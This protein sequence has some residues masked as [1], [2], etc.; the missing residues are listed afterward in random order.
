MTS[1]AAERV[2]GW[3]LLGV[4]TFQAALALGAPWGEAAY[5]GANTGVLPVEQRLSSAVAAPVYLALAGVAFGTVGTPTV[6]RRVLRTASVVIGGGALLNLASPSIVER[7]LW[8]PVTVVAAI[9]LWKAA[10]AHAVP[11]Q[12]QVA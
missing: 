9:A 10:P 2:A 11:V 4:A 12:R 6:R 1:T 7:L 5:G 8:V 3:T